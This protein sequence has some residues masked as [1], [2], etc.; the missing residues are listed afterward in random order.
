MY[1]EAIPKIEREGTTTGTLWFGTKYPV[2]AGRGQKTRSMS[3]FEVKDVPVFA[4]IEDIEDVQHLVQG[5]REK[6]RKEPGM[7]NVSDPGP[8]SYPQD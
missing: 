4:D 1:L 8:L 3:R 6:A 5:L 7:P 2:I